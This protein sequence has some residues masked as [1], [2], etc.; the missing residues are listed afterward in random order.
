MQASRWAEVNSCANAAC[1]RQSRAAVRM[2]RSIGIPFVVMAVGILFRTGNVDRFPI[3]G[4][5]GFASPAT[6]FSQLAESLAL[7]FSRHCNAGA[8]PV[9]TPAQTFG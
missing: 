5:R 6:P 7:F 8:P 4:S 2:V 1:E 3:E 9:G